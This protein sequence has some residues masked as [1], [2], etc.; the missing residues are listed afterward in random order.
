MGANLHAKGWQLVADSLGML[1]TATAGVDLPQL[2]SLVETF[3]GKVDESFENPPQAGPSG[4]SSTYHAKRKMTEGV[5]TLGFTPVYPSFQEEEPGNFSILHLNFTFLP[6]PSLN[7]YIYHHFYESFLFAFTGIEAKHMPK[8]SMK[9]DKAV[10][11]CPFP[12]CT[13]EC[14]TRDNTC[15]HIHRKHLKVVLVC[16]ICDNPMLSMVTFKIHMKQVHTG[17]QLGASQN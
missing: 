14:S 6:L 16:P 3:F 1:E 7:S 9:G 11:P 10:Y 4:H 12:D 13:V 15:T 17:V 8:R 2:W 5:D